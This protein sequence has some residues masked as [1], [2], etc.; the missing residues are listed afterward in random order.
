MENPVFTVGHWFPGD[1]PNWTVLMD[2]KAVGEAILTEPEAQK[3]AEWL[4]TAWGELRS[5]A[6]NDF[7]EACR[8]NACAFCGDRLAVDTQTTCADCR[9]AKGPDVL[10]ALKALC[11]CF[12]DDGIT[13]DAEAVDD[14][15]VQ[16]AEAIAKAEAQ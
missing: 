15:L 9:A 2:G 8:M 13:D 1:P 10:T 4:A 11:D 16:A 7:A 3:C 6:V 5:I 12:D 14:A